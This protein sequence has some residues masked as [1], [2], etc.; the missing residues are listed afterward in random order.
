MSFATRRSGQGIVEEAPPIEIGRDPAVGEYYDANN[1]WWF[2]PNT[3]TLS[4]FWKGSLIINNVSIASTATS[5][6]VGGYRYYRGTYREIFEY[7]A[8]NPNYLYGIYRALP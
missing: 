5:F 1:S 2:N 7:V 8:G 6:V 3:S 4:I